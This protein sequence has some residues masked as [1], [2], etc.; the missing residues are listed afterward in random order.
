MSDID[1]LS[2]D[3]VNGILWASNRITSGTVTNDVLFQIDLAT[4]AIIT[5]AFGV[6]MDY[7]PVPSVPDPTTG[8]PLQDVDD[9]AWDPFQGYLYMIQNQGGLGDVLGYY[10][11]MNGTFHVVGPITQD[12]MEGLGLNYLGQLYGTTGN[13]GGSSFFS[14]D[15]TTGMATLLSVISMTHVDFESVDC[16]AGMSDLALT[17]V[18]SSSQSYP[19]VEGDMVCFDITIYNQGDQDNY[20]IDLVDYIP[21]GLTL[22]DAAWTQAGTNATYTHAGPLAPTQSIVVPICFT[23]DT[24]SQPDSNNNETGVVDNDINGGGP[25]LGE[26]EDD[27]DIAMITVAAYPDCTA[28]NNGPICEGETISITESGGDAASWSWA[29]PQG[30]TSTLQNITSAG[31]T[32]SQSGTYTVTVTDA[33]GLSSTCEVDL[34]VNP[35]P[36]I[37]IN[38]VDPVCNS[39]SP[40]DLVAT[41]SGGTWSGAAISN[42]STGTFD[43]S[44]ANIGNNTV[45][46]EYQDANGCINTASIDVILLSPVG[47]LAIDIVRN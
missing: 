47:C 8:A 38:P 19:I 14:I 9:I 37:T 45:N 42:S 17:K 31:A 10:D 33:L 34:L 2:Y 32:T 3:P 12:D 41:P 35:L 25:L 39:A 40:F 30:F 23:A 44:L 16:L 18:I 4:C 28:S 21:T 27:H 24:D 11:V 1:G 6:G 46:Y 36:I 15:K 26:D 29:G 20:D 13:G 7:I 43:P 22:N 5:D